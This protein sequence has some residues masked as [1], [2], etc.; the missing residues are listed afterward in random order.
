MATEEELLQAVLD[1]PENDAPRLAYADWC[2]RR[3]TPPPDPRGE[4][5]RLQIRYANLENKGRTNE[6][7]PLLEPSE[8]MIRQY[9]ALWAGAVAPLVETYRFRRGFVG[10]VVLSARQFLE[11]ATALFSLAPI[12]HLSLTDAR[13]MVNELAASPDLLRIH[14]LSLRDCGLEDAEVAALAQSRYARALR[15]LSLAGNRLTLEAAEAL[16]GSRFLPRLRYVVFDGNP[17]D[18]NEQFADDG[19][20]ITEAWMP[21][22]GVEL[23]A[24]YGR[25]EWLHNEPKFAWE[26]P[27]NRFDLADR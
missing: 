26:H 9:G 27:P 20:Y 14:S 25:I 24:R 13:G 10:L 16:A 8:L 15:W 7:L 21:P 11:R 18:P 5:I 4:F 17:A 3:S 6:D 23:E 19:H 22:E 12:R 1:E 2:D